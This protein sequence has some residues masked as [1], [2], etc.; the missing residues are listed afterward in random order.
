MSDTLANLRH[1]L[2][3]A[4]QLA[5]VVR[6]MK[7]VAAT[8]IGQYE[9]AVQALVE[10]QRSVNL[11]LSLCLREEQLDITP[12]IPSVTDRNRPIGALLFGSD[13]GLV[14]H[15]NEAVASFALEKLAKLPG[16]KT[17]WTVGDRVNPYVESAPL[18]IKR[19]FRVPNSVAAITSLVTE[20][21]I[22]LEAHTSRT[23]QT[24]VHVFHNHPLAGSRYE[25]VSHRLLPLD[26]AWCRD[27]LK[28]PWPDNRAAQLLGA[29]AANLSALVHEHLFIGLYRACA[30][31]LASENAS[32]L[33]AMQRAQKNIGTMS[34]TLHRS[35]NRLR[36]SQIDEELFDV[37]AG[38]NA[39]TA[40]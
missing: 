27:L 1:K 16:P 33:E 31:S 12:L 6:A 3:S 5:S 10:Y 23:P 39:L 19:R 29:G 26:V 35:I 21:Q 14:G 13:Q 9:A 8:S 28:I 22:E 32:R 2:K 24:E 11:G 37:V 25:P 34:D 40:N 36:Q 7:A 17:V 18:A 20:I 4:E 38:F 15:F 30:E